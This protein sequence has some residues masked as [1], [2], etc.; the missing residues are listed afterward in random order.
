VGLNHGLSPFLSIPLEIL[1]YLGLIAATA[2]SVSLTVKTRKWRTL[3]SLFKTILAE[4]E[5]ADKLGNFSAL[6]RVLDRGIPS[7]VAIT[8]PA[9][10]PSTFKGRVLSVPNIG[11]RDCVRY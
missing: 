1:S 10:N 8:S 11:S 6:A 7:A 9:S 4:P 5:N 2:Y 3:P